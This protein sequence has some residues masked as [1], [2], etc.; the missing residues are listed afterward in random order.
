MKMAFL[1][2]P[3]LL[4]SQPTIPPKISKE[5]ILPKTNDDFYFVG[6]GPYAGIKL[7]SDKQKWSPLAGTEVLVGKRKF[8]RSHA[9]DYIVGGVFYELSTPVPIPYLQCSYLHF[10]SPPSGIYFGI[11]LT[12]TV[13]PLVL[14]VSPNLPLWAYMLPFNVPL[15]LGYQRKDSKQFT[16]L[17]VGP[18]MTYNVSI[19]HGIGF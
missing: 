13:N 17:Q 6:G 7:L 12:G 2:I 18:F 1:L 16:Q 14:M 9:I 10:P 19:S 5:M 8:S 15:T 4:T 11:G 3:A